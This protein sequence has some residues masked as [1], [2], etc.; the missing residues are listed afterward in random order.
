[1]NILSDPHKE[2]KILWLRV[3]LSAWARDLLMPQSREELLKTFLCIVCV[4]EIIFGNKNTFFK[5]I[6]VRNL[7]WEA[8]D[9]TET[10]QR[11]ERGKLSVGSQLSCCGCGDVSADAEGAREVPD[12]QETKEEPR[13]ANKSP[14]SRRAVG[15]KGDGRGRALE[16]FPCE[17]LCVPN[18]TVWPFAEKTAFFPLTFQK[19]KLYPADRA[20][21][22]PPSSDGWTILAAKA[23]APKPLSIFTTATP[24]TQEQSMVESA[25]LPPA[26]TP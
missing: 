13:W 7:L 16:Q 18:H 10:K 3:F 1:M 21:R 14:G 8:G 24:G 22:S 5:H 17:T 6:D 2:E 26:P 15:A 9:R 23:A 25:A 4:N 20:L 12:V 11:R 19:Q